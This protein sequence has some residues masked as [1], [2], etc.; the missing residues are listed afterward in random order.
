MFLHI[1]Q[2]KLLSVMKQNVAKFLTQVPSYQKDVLSLND[3]VVD[4]QVQEPSCW[5]RR[6][7]PIQ[8][9][10]PMRIA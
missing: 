7:S 5:D 3:C 8:L 4:F 9:Q 2:L 10:L 6:N 1:L